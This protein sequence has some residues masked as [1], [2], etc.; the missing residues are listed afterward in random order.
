VDSSQYPSFGQFNSET[1][2]SP[3]IGFVATDGI[4]LY[5]QDTPVQKI[6]K[7]SV[8]DIKDL[9]PHGGMRTSVLND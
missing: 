5:I 4:I 1:A 3:A 9:R 8:K 6:Y 2:C 7:T